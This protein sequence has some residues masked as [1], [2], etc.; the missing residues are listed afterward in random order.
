MVVVTWLN[1]G[2]QILRTISLHYD[3]S[4]PLMFKNI[5]GEKNS[6]LHNSSTEIRP[7]TITQLGQGSQTYFK[8]G[9]HTNIARNKFQCKEKR[10]DRYRASQW[11]QSSKRGPTESVK[12]SSLYIDV[13]IQKID[14][15]YIAELGREFNQ[16]TGSELASQ[17]HVF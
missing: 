8:H 6:L 12:P 13:A 1:M 17:K 10:L 5:C 3:T 2:A 9:L 16:S 11:Q 14:L 4:M 15:N 7:E